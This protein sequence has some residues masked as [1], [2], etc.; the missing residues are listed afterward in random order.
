MGTSFQ[1]KYMEQIKKIAEE[2]RN[3]ELPAVTEEL[4][5]LF[6]TTG[7]RLK[8]EEVYFMRRK[9]LAVFGMAAYIWKRKEDVAKLT[10]VLENICGEECWALPAHVNRKEGKEWRITVDLFASETAQALSEIL[11][12]V[13]KSLP[14]E[15][16]I[17]VELCAKV[18]TE[19][20]RR[21]LVPFFSSK[22]NYGGWE[23]ADH[24]WN[25]VCA[26]SIGSACI[27]LMEGK[28]EERLEQC[29]KRICHSLEFYLNG[30]KEDG[31][32]MEGI[33]YFTYGMTYFTGFAEQLLRYSKGTINLFENEKVKNIALFQQKMYFS[34]GKTV[35]FSDGDRDAKFRMGLTCFLAK[36]YEGVRI[37]PEALAADFETDLCYRFMGLMRD[38]L[39]TEEERVTE[40][41]DAALRHDILPDA[42]WSICEGANGAAMAIKGGTNAEPHNHNDVGSFIYLAD[43]EFMVTDLGAGEYTKEYF[44]E[45]RY[46]IL[47]NSSLGHSVP[48]IG[49]QKQKCGAEYGA[50]EFTA[51]GC[52]RTMVEFAGAYP[53]N[54][55]N[56]L[57]REA[58]FSMDSGALTVTD[59]FDLPKET[60]FFTEQIV[61][62]CEVELTE[63]GAWLRGKQHDCVLQ[64][65]EIVKFIWCQEKE[66][67]N[68]QGET[69]I[70]RLLQ[71]SVPL[72]PGKENKGSTWF[73]MIAYK[74]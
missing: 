10:E 21:V 61:T 43:E 62:Q 70:V 24:N 55:V 36:Q 30:F 16:K 42:Q 4:F 38:Y 2:L 39:W 15:C 27:Y 34:S 46:Q 41:F 72:Q 26:G 28:N 5:A 49:G 25:A 7:N 37:P 68:H 23:C 6:E 73:A 56:R 1:K 64:L 44:G 45:G 33:G 67:K 22:P 71:W 31:T 19:I 3:L 47:C 69:E 8:Y 9:F 66:H 14:E 18:E 74:K 58:D 63:H 12:L 11:G 35:S 32:C 65:P 54:V 60:I 40:V 17:P 50:S 52:G 13:N 51:D 57:V 48:L 20:E 59:C 29:L 53:G